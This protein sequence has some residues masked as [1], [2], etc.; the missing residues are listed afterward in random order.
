[1]CDVATSKNDTNQSSK[2]ESCIKEGGGGLGHPT[3]V[4]GGEEWGR[5]HFCNVRSEVAKAVCRLLS[6]TL[7]K[8]RTAKNHAHVGDPTKEMGGNSIRKEQ[9]IKKGIRAFLSSEEWVIVFTGRALLGTF[10]II[11]IIKYNI[12]FFSF[13]RKASLWQSQFHEKN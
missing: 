8:M 12:S 11:G 2:Q 6:A 4:S 10:C 9:G 7:L 1:M 5:C 13:L 3:N